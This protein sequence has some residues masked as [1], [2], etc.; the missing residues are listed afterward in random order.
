MLTIVTI[1]V[2][3]DSLD[4]EEEGDKMMVWPGGPSHVPVCQQQAPPTVSSLR[5]GLKPGC[6]RV[7]LRGT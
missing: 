4:G 2:H 7:A 5:A 1:A 3:D 6:W